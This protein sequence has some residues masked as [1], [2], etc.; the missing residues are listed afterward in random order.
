VT[1]HDHRTCDFPCCPGTRPHSWY[2][3]IVN[4]RVARVVSGTPPIVSTNVRLDTVYLSGIGGG[5]FMEKRPE[6]ERHRLAFE[7]LSAQALD[8]ESSGGDRPPYKQEVLMTAPSTYRWFKSS[9]SG[10]S[11]TECVEAAFVPAGVLVR[12][13]KVPDGPHLA[14]SA[15][16]WCRFV[17]SAAR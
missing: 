11:G 13:S 6:L 10:G 12:D 17:G 9:Y 7:Y 1:S 4:T 5:L 15:E 14:V 2:D 8:L 3:G 16:G